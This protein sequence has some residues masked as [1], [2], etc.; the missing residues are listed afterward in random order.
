MFWVRS[1][2][3]AQ[4]FQRSRVIHLYLFVHMNKSK[5]KLL[6]TAGNAGR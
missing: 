3:K 5:Y 4:E 6:P 1:E 2:T